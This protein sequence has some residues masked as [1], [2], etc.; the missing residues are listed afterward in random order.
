MIKFRNNMRLRFYYGGLITHLLSAQGIEE[1]AC[2]L[3]ISFHSDL[4]GKL[5]DMVR[6]KGFDTSH[7]SILFAL[8][9]PAFDDNIMARMFGM[10]ELQLQIG[11]CLLLTLIWKLWPNI[12][13]LLRV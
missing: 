7:G 3:T 1:E 9:S 4:T 10:D 2:D 8:E 6:T 12:I 11:G 13:P 5:F